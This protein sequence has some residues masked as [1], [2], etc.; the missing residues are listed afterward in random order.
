MG[1]ITTIAALEALYNPAPSEASLVKVAHKMTPEYAAWIGA[2]KFC[3]LST[4]GPGGTDGSPRGDDG[5]VV[6]IYDDH[7][8][9]MPDWR[10][11]TRLDSLR[12]II[13]DGRVSLM[14]MINGQNIVIRVNGTAKLTTD[15]ALVGRFEQG[16]KQP[17][18]VVVVTI[19]EIYSQCARALLRAKLWGDAPDLTLPSMGDILRAQTKGAIDG[20]AYDRDWAGRALNTMW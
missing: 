4:V 1:D 5:P 20:Q 9:L 17:Q 15:P 13:S 14:F 8:L 18:S 6:D 2:A 12:N 10:G 19:G 11:N 7:T 16:G 3:L